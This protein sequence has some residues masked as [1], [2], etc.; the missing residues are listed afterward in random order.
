MIG[1]PPRSHPR[2]AVRREQKQGGLET[3]EKELETD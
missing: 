2:H 3:P 1:L